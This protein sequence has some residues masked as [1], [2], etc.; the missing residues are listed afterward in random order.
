VQDHLLRR[1][2]RDIARYPLLG[3][4]EE[5]ESV[6]AVAQA[7]TEHWVALLSYLPVAESILQRLTQDVA[8]LSELDRRKLG[9]LD[10]L[11][12]LARVRREQ[13]SELNPGQL[14][15]WRNVSKELGRA[16]RLHD[17]DRVWMA[18]ANRIAA[19]D[20]QVGLTECPAALPTPAY[21]RYLARIRDTDRRQ[22]EAKHRL[23]TANLRL[24]VTIA[25]RSVRGR[26]ALLD[27]IQEGNIGLIKAVERFDPGHEVRF[28]TYAS[29]WIFSAIHRALDNKGRT[30]RVPT[31]M[32]AAHSQVSRAIRAIMTRTGREPTLD[33]LS[34]QT[35]LRQEKIA[36][37]CALSSAPAFSLNPP[38]DGEHGFRFVHS[39]SE[40]EEDGLSSFDCVANR[41]WAEEVQ[42]LLCSLKP[43]ENRVIR[44]RF[45]WDEE[46]SLK[47]VGK[48]CNLTGERI[49]GIQKQALAKLRR[50]V[51]GAW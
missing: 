15:A 35:G 4:A 48:K 22:R 36:K 37:V 12:E 19:T 6:R 18:S 20:P 33:E 47:Q 46:L 8:S 28:S 2:F 45:G 31:H 23:V 1:Y 41:R 9:Q 11:R 50:R 7:E 29:W 24:V 25:Y 44:W 5:L 32:L 39:L 10:Q 16:L 14:R 21:R 26:L 51:R 30:V 13:R 42:K 40:L 43:V 27:L 49:R 34:R 3:P 38:G 17:A